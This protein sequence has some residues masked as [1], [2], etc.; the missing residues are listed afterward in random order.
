MAK[1]GA[2]WWG[3]R[4]ALKTADSAGAGTDGKISLSWSCGSTAATNG[5]LALDCGGLIA[6]LGS[7]LVTGNADKADDTCFEQ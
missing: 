4:V 3:W 7:A 6:T 1:R 2:G 5:A